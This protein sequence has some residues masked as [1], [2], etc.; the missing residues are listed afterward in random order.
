MFF[1]PNSESILPRNISP[2]WVVGVGASYCYIKPTGRKTVTKI[3]KEDASTQIGAKYVDDDKYPRALWQ[4]VLILADL[5]GFYVY[6]V[7]QDTVQFTVD[8]KNAQS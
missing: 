7:R 8:T 2:L 4:H 6:D 3:S 5:G 1:C